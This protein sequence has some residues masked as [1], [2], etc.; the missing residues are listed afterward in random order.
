MA[1]NQSTGSLRV[2]DL[3]NEDDTD[4]Q[5]DWDSDKISFKT[6]NTLRFV[7]DNT[8]CG[9]G[10]ASPETLLHIQAGSAGTIATTDGALLT[11]ESNEKPKIHFQ[12]PNAYGG[13]IIFGSVADN[14]EGQIDYDHGSDRFLFKTAG[15]TKMAILGDNVG[16]GVSDPDEKLEV[17]GAIHI[18]AELG[19]GDIPS[20]PAANDGGVLYGKEDGKLYYKSN[21]VAETDI[22]SGGGGGSE[23]PNLVT[24]GYLKVSGSSTLGDASGDSVTIN[25]GTVGVPNLPSSTDNTVMVV[26]SSNQIGTDEINAKVWGTQLIENSGTPL[27]NQVATWG[28][29][30]T[31]AGE[32]N[33]IFDGSRLKITGKLS[34]SANINSVGYI[35][36]AAQLNASGS[37]TIKGVGRISGS[38]RAS[39]S[40]VLGDRA[41]VNTTLYSEDIKLVNVPAG[42]DNSVLVKDSNGLMKT[43][44][45]DGRVW[46]SSLVDVTGVSKALQIPIF[47]DA[48]TIT[49]SNVIRWVGPQTTLAVTGAIRSQGQIHITE[50]GYATTA[51]TEKWL[52]FYTLSEANAPNNATYINQMVVPFGGQ[53]KRVYFRPSGSQHTANPV[54]KLY[55][56]S[57]PTQLINANDSGRYVET[58]SISMAAGPAKVGVF[59]FTGSNH[60][61][62]GDVVGVS[63][64]PAANPVE[65]NATCVWEYDVL[66]V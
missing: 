18:S 6:D 45:I 8:G 16:I 20:T 12:S 61:S 46:G 38:F 64:D 24:A 30:T 36:T 54:A 44:E 43:D 58:V 7:I 29:T 52:P 5:I 1:Y 22:T 63:I 65:V 40:V 25:A 4:T 33:L 42:T 35:T 48:N 47:S 11:L 15:A 37:A 2:G 60:F 39:G 14:D 57:S 17:S 31:L 41:S 9:I 49:G 53:L 10:V 59:I 50:H 27:N 13:S 34:A 21:T 28:G 3:L 51:T 55:K 32:S 66:G 56:A 26:N 19:G 62:A 23:S